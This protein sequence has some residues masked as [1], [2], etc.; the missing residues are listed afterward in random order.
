LAWWTTMALGG[1]LPA[2]GLAAFTSAGLLLATAALFRLS[3]PVWQEWVITWLATS[4]TFLLARR[5][6][7]RDALAISS[8]DGKAAA[9]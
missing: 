9:K 5:Q 3:Y 7:A 2:L 8:I 6:V 1:R 4:G